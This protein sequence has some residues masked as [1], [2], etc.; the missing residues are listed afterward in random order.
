MF[1]AKNSQ[2]RSGWVLLLVVLAAIAVVTLLGLAL[3]QARASAQSGPQAPQDIPYGLGEAWLPAGA[4]IIDNLAPC[5]EF[6]LVVDTQESLSLGIPFIQETIVSAGDQV[7]MAERNPIVGLGSDSGS[8][9][10]YAV[11]QLGIVNA[12]FPLPANTPLTVKMTLYQGT[13]ATPVYH[14]TATLVCNTAALQVLEAGPLAPFPALADITGRSGTSCLAGGVS[15][16]VDTNLSSEVVYPLQTTVRDSSGAVVLDDRQLISGTLATLSLPLQ[17]DLPPNENLSTTL[18]LR[19]PNGRPLYRSTATLQCNSGFNNFN[20]GTP[21]QPQQPA[22]TL[23]EVTQPGCAS[24]QTIFGVN[25]ITEAGQSYFYEMRMLSGSSVLLER[26][27]Q[28][29]FDGEFQEPGINLWSVD[30]DLPAGSP[31]Q[32]ELALYD[33]LERPRYRTTFDYQCDASNPLSNVQVTP[34]PFLYL[35]SLLVP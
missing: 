26:Y 31:V 14:S 29:T 15:L 7:Y 4:T 3:A 13:L 16:N 25:Q 32:V 28:D 6:G 27:E 19:E 24:G 8:I 30:V 34:Y 2:H 12:S 21:A 33:E 11:D 22:L 5:G 20:P 9:P 17:A 35:P 23:A 18:T 10:L 1:K